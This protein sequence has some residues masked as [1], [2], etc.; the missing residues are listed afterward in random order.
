[1]SRNNYNRPILLSIFAILLVL[2]GTIMVINGTLLL[3]GGT[4]LIPINMPGAIGSGASGGLTALFGII[5][6]LIGMALFSGKSWGWWFAV[7]MTIISLVFSIASLNLAL[8][9][10]LIVLIYLLLRNTRGWFGV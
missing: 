9:I 4:E 8:L 7:I 2:S 5:N 10:N 3:F 6:I 1:M